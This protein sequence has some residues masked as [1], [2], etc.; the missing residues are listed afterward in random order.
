M[1]VEEGAS[2]TATEPDAGPAQSE[3]ETENKEEEVQ[4]KTGPLQKLDPE[5]DAELEKKAAAEP[6]VLIG[7]ATEIHPQHC[8]GAYMEPQV[9][10]SNIN[11]FRGTF[12]VRKGKENSEK[13]P[14]AVVQTDADGVFSVELPE[15]AYCLVESS[16]KN[17]P[18]GTAKGG[19]EAQCLKEH[20]KRCDAIV[21]HPSKKPVYIALHRT[22]FGPC[23]M[24]PLPP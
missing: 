13:K 21:E 7:R 6:D 10:L 9:P 5:L 2:A 3:H 8:G 24:G 14:V 23:Y 16:K 20:W 12:L 15:G 11:A 4:A 1:L 22:C 19:A 18:K 17:P